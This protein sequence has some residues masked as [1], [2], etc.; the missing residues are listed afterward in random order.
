[1]RV[2]LF[3]F[4]FVFFSQI[5]ISQE[6]KWNDFNEAETQIKKHPKKYIFVDLYTD[7]CGW[8]KLMD[9]KTF[10]DPEVVK[11]LNKKFIPVKFD[12]QD[13][14]PQVFFEKT[15]S[16]DGTY[17]E[18]ARNILRNELM[19]PSFVIINQYGLV[20]KIIN[21]FQTKKELLDELS[22]L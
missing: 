3:I 10:T 5:A 17:N 14:N 8:C 4:T 6:I 2:F 22:K 9:K 13:Q 21:G 15:Y 19:F 11:V 16:F 1:M 12:A 7:W 20:E 18:L